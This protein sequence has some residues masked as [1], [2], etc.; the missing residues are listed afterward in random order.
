MTPYVCVAGGTKGGALVSLIH[1]HTSNGD[2]FIRTFTDN[3]LE[4]VSKPF[5]KTLQRWLFTGDLHD[6]YHEFFVAASP[7]LADTQSAGDLVGDGGFG[8]GIG[9]D[10][11]GADDGVGGL[12]LW[13][14]KYTF[15]RK[16]LPSFLSEEF[17]RKVGSR[18]TLFECEANIFGSSDFLDWQ[19]LEFYPI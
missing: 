1:S 16:M 14:K 6:P 18:T 3:L 2:P 13:E 8:V 4:E 15:R 11:V 17:G 5:F 9:G 7:D 19:E 12:M 10:S